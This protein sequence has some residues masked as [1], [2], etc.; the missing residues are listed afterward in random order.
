MPG[1]IIHFKMFNHQCFCLIDTYNQEH[2]SVIKVVYCL[3]CRKGSAER[4]ILAQISCLEFSPEIYFY[5][6]LNYFLAYCFSHLHNGNVLRMF[7]FCPVFPL[8][9]PFA[10]VNSPRS[11]NEI[12]LFKRTL[13]LTESAFLGLSV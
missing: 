1:N 3:T 9:L 11:G 2:H 6:F 4:G 13:M 10:S 5:H 7:I 8:S 12:D